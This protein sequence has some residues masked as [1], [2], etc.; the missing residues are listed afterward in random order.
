MKLSKTQHLD[1]EQKWLVMTDMDG[2]LLNHH[3]YGF[4]AAKPTL[5]SLD[6]NQIPV[7]LNTSKTFA[8]LVDLQVQLQL[9][10]PFVVENGSA[11]YLPEAYFSNDFVQTNLTD[12]RLADAYRVKILGQKLSELQN[13]VQTRQVD[14]INFIQC[15]VEQAVA[16][17]GLSEEQARQAQQRQFSLP[18]YFQ[19][20]HAEEQFASEAEHAGFRCLR[21]GRFLHL[22]GQTDKGQ[23]LLWL[24][25]CYKQWYG[26]AIQVLALGDSHNDLAMLEQA[27]RA[28]VV[29]TDKG[30]GI[31]LPQHPNLIQTQNSAPEGWAEGVE[32]A[33]IHPAATQ[34]GE[35]NG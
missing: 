21:G 27:D 16:L 18:L 2:T 8:E 6:Q 17:T 35:M 22:M 32:R 23:A 26:E 10:S 3:D 30:Y 25:N 14:A 20:P 29:R 9:E 33:L 12:T 28:V 24:K 1:T 11:V 31:E 4:E 34:S 7:I 5:A 19:N 13:Y 15:S